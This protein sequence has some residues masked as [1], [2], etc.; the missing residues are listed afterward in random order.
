MSGGCGLAWEIVFARVFSNA[1][2]N[3]FEITGLVLVS[4]F[5]G[6]AIG[7]WFSDRILQHLALIEISIGLWSGL[8]VLLLSFW[9]LEMMA[10]FPPGPK[11]SLLL[12]GLLVPPMAMI[13]TCVPL[14]SYAL[15]SAKRS[16]SSSFLLTYIAYNLG[17]FASVLLIEFVLL[18]YAGLLVASGFACGLNIL[19]GVSLVWFRL[20]SRR[21]APSGANSG[22]KKRAFHG[23]KLDD[24]PRSIVAALFLASMASGIFQLLMLK[25]SFKVYGPIQEN[26]AVLLAAAI[27]GV[28]V[29][30]GLARRRN[31]SLPTTIGATAFAVLVLFL[32]ASVLVRSWGWVNVLLPS[33]ALVIVGKTLLLGGPPFVV[34]T[35]FGMLV[36]VAV[37]AC[38]EN[39]GQ[40][41]RASNAGRLLAI[42]SAGNGVG[43][44]IMFLWLYKSFPMQAIFV[45]VF[46]ILVVGQAAALFGYNP[47]VRDR[48]LQRLP[49]RLLGATILAMGLLF[50]GFSL[51]P[52]T[53]LL[54]GYKVLS[55]AEMTE[56][57]V[58]DFKE[59]HVFRSYDQDAAL[60]DF[61]NGSRALIFNG[62]RSLTFGPNSRATLHEVVVGSTPALFSKDRDNA[63]VLGLGSGVTAGAT[64]RLYSNTRIVEINPAMVNVPAYLSAENA[65]LMHRKSASVFF[66]D[67]VSRLVAGG[68]RY[69]A[70]VNTVTSPKYFSASK[71]YTKDFYDLVVRRLAPGGAYS[72][73]FDLNIGLEGVSVML[74]TLE[75]SFEQCRYFVLSRGYFNVVCGNDDLLYR[76]R[77]VVE[78]RFQNTGIEEIFGDHGLP[79]R[80]TDAIRLSEISFGD[81]FFARESLEIN[82]LNR[83]VIEFLTIGAKEA[84]D[85]SR[86]LAQTLVKNIASKRRLS[87]AQGDW[88]ASCHTIKWLAHMQVSGC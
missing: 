22:I 68:F 33:G 83:P 16:G 55:N 40:N 9:G 69:D 62:F 88:R 37:K 44:L 41:P 75:A 27:L 78:A 79:V 23:S 19:V 5:F 7:A 54:L 28:A 64:A 11:K 81:R 84:D 6:I 60:V 4:V 72:S 30:S 29:G 13:G 1:F 52:G 10:H 39:S 15:S 38:G 74:N 24:P 77:P 70:I 50:C 76:S 48:V 82:T 67:G 46:A 17:A 61:K 87:F 63:L 34:F 86:T 47:H 80:A 8:T 65:D 25:F 2:G 31:D 32:F 66:E 21:A 85:A 51:W 56:I 45:S 58:S 59:A 73:W 42:S 26:F 14:F 36:P 35:L 57:Q 43:A 71:I 53:A 20:G 12:L 3:G 49:S 18:R